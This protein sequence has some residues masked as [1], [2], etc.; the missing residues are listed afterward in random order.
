MH[1]F[2]IKQMGGNPIQFQWM[3][4]HK[5]PNGP[6]S[7]RGKRKPH[8]NSLLKNWN[9][10]EKN[11]GLLLGRWQCSKDGPMDKNRFCWGFCTHP[12]L[13]QLF[14]DTLG[15]VRKQ[16]L[17]VAQLPIHTNDGVCEIKAVQHSDHCTLL[18]PKISTK[19][20]FSCV[21]STSQKY[22]E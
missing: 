11:R 21:I 20:A 6:R 16:R 7:A 18:C 13:P 9:K 5:P 3:W 14:C 17:A 22:G 4:F 12:Q 1:N 2:D 19:R 8:T 15:L 10:W